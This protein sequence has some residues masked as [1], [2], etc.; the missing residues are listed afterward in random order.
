MFARLICCLCSWIRVVCISSVFDVSEGMF[1]RVCEVV[2]VKGRSLW[3][4][5]MSPPP[6]P[7]CLSCLSVVYPGNL[8]VFF[9]GFEFGFLDS[10][11]VYVVCV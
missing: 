6:P 1:A 9:C 10:G 7:R 5:V 3:I 8:G 4:R 2:F 11:Y